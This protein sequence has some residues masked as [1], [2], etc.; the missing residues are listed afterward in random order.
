MFSQL[1]LW[2]YPLSGLMAL[3]ALA[4]LA[5]VLWRGDLCPGQ[6]SRITQQSF[7]VWVI[8]GLSVML[9]VEAK[10]PQWQIWLGGTALVLG[11]GVSLLQSRLEGKRAIPGHWLWLPALPLALYGVGLLTRSGWVSGLLQ[12]VLLGAAFAHLMLLR[13]RHRLQAFNTLLPMAGLGA[14]MASLLWFAA[15]MLVHSPSEAVLADL[16]PWILTQASLL[17]AALLLWFSPLYR[18]QETAP[19]VLSVTLCG[20]LIA[21][22]A[23]TGA[24]QRLV[25]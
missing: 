9:A 21:E 16:L 7:S 1:P 8:T 10:A 11:I 6:R 5:L 14:A 25:L 4:W 24:L 3:G 17:I 18:Q 2:L 20:L 13:A 19:V 15:L 23:A 22:I 12:M